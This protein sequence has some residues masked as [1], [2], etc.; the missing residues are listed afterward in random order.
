M[1]TK[2]GAARNY[3]SRWRKSNQRATSRAKGRRGKT[4][5]TRKVFICCPLEALRKRGK[6][7]LLLNETN[8]NV[9]RETNAALAGR[10]SEGLEKGK[11]RRKGRKRE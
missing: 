10:N 8:Q 1:K 3:A 2:N 6:L 11:N 9:E 7:N 4:G 5:G